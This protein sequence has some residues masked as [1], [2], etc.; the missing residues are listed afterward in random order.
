MAFGGGEDP[1]YNQATGFGG[2]ESPP[3]ND[4]FTGH[5]KSFRPFWWARMPTLQ[6]PAVLLVGWKT[7]LRLFLLTL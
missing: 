1:A 3:Y 6:A 7:T 5:L 2:L 4:C